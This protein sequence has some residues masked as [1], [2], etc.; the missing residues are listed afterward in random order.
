MTGCRLSLRFTAPTKL[1]FKSDRL[2]KLQNNKREGSDR[3]MA[4]MM[5]IVDY[6]GYL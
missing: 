2:G 4:M 3:I 1:H 6:L 5:Q